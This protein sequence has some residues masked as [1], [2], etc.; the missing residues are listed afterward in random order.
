MALCL[1]AGGL[2][3]GVGSAASWLPSCTASATDGSSPA[4]AE[5]LPEL[6]TVALDEAVDSSGAARTIHVAKY[7]IAI[8]DW[9]RCA[10]AGDCT[11]TPRRR[12]YQDGDPPANLGFR[13]V[14]DDEPAVT[15]LGVLQTLLQ[16][17]HIQS[18]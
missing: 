18:V 9:N 16:R 1:L 8:T 12:P 7:E 6:V 10:A 5:V 13:V 15:R 11:F 2:A 3:F 4:A 14:L 17:L